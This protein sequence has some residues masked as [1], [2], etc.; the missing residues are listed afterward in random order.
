MITLPT[1][2]LLA[3][4][5]TRRVLTLIPE[6]ASIQMAAVSTAVAANTPVHVSELAQAVGVSERSLRTAFNECYQIGPRR[7]LQLRQLHGI[8]RDLV[9]AG[10]DETTVTDVM[11]RWGI[12]EFGRCAGIYRG[13]F[14]ELP[15]ETLRRQRPLISSSS[16]T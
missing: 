12:W 11:T 4:K 13:D 15:S 9:A 16:A 7:Y 1:P 2:A 14:G 10:L 6:D 3:S 8:R 5:N